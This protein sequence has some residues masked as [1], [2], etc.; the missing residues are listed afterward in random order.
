MTKKSPDKREQNRL[1]KVENEKQRKR[2]LAAEYVMEGCSLRVA[3]SNVGMSTYFVSE[4]RDRLLDRRVL[5]RPVKGR[6]KTV[7]TYEWKK[8][9]RE[10]LKTRKPGPE[11][12]NCPKT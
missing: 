9:Y 1:K 12:G 3:A 11:P 8:G 10:L 2:Y 5:R 4:W 7:L 6:L